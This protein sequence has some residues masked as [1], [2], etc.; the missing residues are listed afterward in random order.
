MHLACHG[1]TTIIAAVKLSARSF[2]LNRQFLLGWALS[3]ILLLSFAGVCDLFKILKR[4][5]SSP[6]VRTDLHAVF[7]TNKSLVCSQAWAWCRLHLPSN[8]GAAAAALWQPLPGTQAHR[9]ARRRLMV[10]SHCRLIHI[11]A[12][13]TNIQSLSSS[14]RKF[15]RIFVAGE[16]LE[17]KR[18]F[19]LW[20]ILLIRVIDL[21]PRFSTH[22]LGFNYSKWQPPGFIAT[23]KTTPVP[24]Q[25]VW[26]GFLVI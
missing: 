20:N 9:T 17:L 8:E 7:S 22:L 6:C 1:D 18:I 21:Q 11:Q 10:R 15:F 19:C 13:Q 26:Y 12:A 14:L 24:I 2:C 4:I 16:S 3:E 25:N 5:A 23:Y